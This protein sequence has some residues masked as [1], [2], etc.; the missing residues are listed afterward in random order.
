[1]SSIY[2]YL[3]GP[4][5]QYFLFFGGCEM[6]P[7]K[8]FPLWPAQHIHVQLSQCTQGKEAGQKHQQI[9]TCWLTMRENILFLLTL[10][11][12]WAHPFSLGCDPE[13][14]K[15]FQLHRQ[16]THWR[17]DSMSSAWVV[18]MPGSNYKDPKRQRNFPRY[19]R[20]IVAK[21]G[22]KASG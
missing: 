13:F 8:H 1:M 17:Q 4:V 9:N 6:Q 2:S 19:P 3:P 15:T 10:S 7:Q 11:L 12:H 16:Q 18:T 21:W 5:L 22:L 20:T 14:K